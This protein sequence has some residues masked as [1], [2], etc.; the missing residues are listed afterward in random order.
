MQ[1]E[2][3]EHLHRFVE[4]T[5]G[6]GRYPSR[7]DVL[8]EALKLLQERDEWLDNLEAKLLERCRAIRWI[9]L[10]TCGTGFGTRSWFLN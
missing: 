4:E 7:D 8:V 10:R 9:T 1:V 6:S 2:L 3:P 5:V